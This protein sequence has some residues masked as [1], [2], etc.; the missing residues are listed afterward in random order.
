[1]MVSQRIRLCTVVAAL[2]AVGPAPVAAQLPPATVSISPVLELQNVQAGHVFVG[3]VHPVRRSVVGSS[4]DGRVVEFPVNAGDRVTA[5]Q[6]LAKLLTRQLEIQIAAAEADQRLKQEELNEL[7]NGARPEELK[8]VKARSAVAQALHDYLQ[9][10]LQRSKSLFERNALSEELLQDDVSKALAGAQQLVAAQAAEELIVAGPRAEKIAQAQARADMAQEE[11]NRLNDLLVKHTIVSPFDGYV[12]REHTEVGQWIKS[13]ELVAEVEE[14]TH[15]ELEAQVLE[16]YLDHVRPGTEARI[17][18][19]AVPNRLFVGKVTRVI[20]HGDERSRNFPVRLR[21][22]NQFAADGEPVLKSGMFARVWLPTEHR[23]SVL[24]VPQD[25]LVLG[26]PSPMVYIARPDPADAGKLKAAPVPIQIGTVFG[27]YVEVIGPLEK[28][29]N[30]VIEGNERLIPGQELRVV[31]PSK[32]AAPPPVSAP[33][34]PT[35]A[36]PTSTS[37]ATPTSAPPPTAANQP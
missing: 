23:D 27:S 19:P 32:T 18:I 30:V 3:S 26:G 17:E 31:P 2:C 12:V 7:K 20:P 36:L 16:S 21:M 14:L 37:V 15:V 29:L 8:E 6:P 22:E 5:K 34:Q 10:K 4:V 28:G 24:T 1:M 33:A 9:Q 11:V 13:G 25:A 35:S